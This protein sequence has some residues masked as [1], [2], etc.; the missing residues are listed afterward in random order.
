[1]DI[2]DRLKQI[3]I[4]L[5]ALIIGFTIHEF[6][7]AFVADKL[8]DKTPRFQGRLSLNPAAHIDPMGLIMIILVGFG[9][10]KPVQT[11]PYAYKNYRMDD[12]KVSIAG[13]IS[14]LIVAVI[15]TPI[16]FLYIFY[17][18]PVI[19]NE[20]LAMVLLLMINAIV[21]YNIM[22]FIF[23]LIPIPPLD[24]FIYLRIYFLLSLLN[25]SINMVNINYSF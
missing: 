9:W 13:P 22:L 17:I 7:H 21:K 8:G 16:L 5:P 24:G 12:L 4:I 3:P 11:N 19:P 23:N 18:A 1:M 6:A 20:K 10:A 15:F 2:I 25:L 14:N